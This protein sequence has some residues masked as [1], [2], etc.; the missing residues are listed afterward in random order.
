MGEPTSL[1]RAGLVRLN[2]T[3]GQD[4]SMA[5]GSTGLRVRFASVSWAFR[6]L[7]LPQAGPINGMTCR[8]ETGQGSGAGSGQG[9]GP[10]S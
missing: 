9:R 2:K 3:L 10:R 8:V 6:I 7:L 5:R 1:R 4:L